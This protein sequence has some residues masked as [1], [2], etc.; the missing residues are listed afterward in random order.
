M[1][2]FSFDVRALVI[3]HQC[4]RFDRY[5]DGVAVVI[6]TFPVPQSSIPHNEDEQNGIA[7]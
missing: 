3:V 2:R 6:V 1:S 4:L 5:K 7:L